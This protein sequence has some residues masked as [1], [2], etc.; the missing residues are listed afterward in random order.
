MDYESR[1][2]VLT[3]N[4]VS[5]LP[6]L[7]RKIFILYI[8]LF[9]AGFSTLGWNHPGFSGSTVSTCLI[10]LASV[11]QYQERYLMLFRELMLQ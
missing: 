6:S 3:K 8:F 1:F 5:M 10:G 9:A 11:N 2:R 4:V 7:Q